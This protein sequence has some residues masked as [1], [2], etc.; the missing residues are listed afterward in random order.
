MIRIAS[1]T[2]RDIHSE[3][4]VL[5]VLSG[6]LRPGRAPLSDS[7]S[8]PTGSASAN[9]DRHGR[10]GHDIQWHPATGRAVP[11]PGAAPPGTL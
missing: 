1:A 2:Y 11:V 7:D 9:R 5:P 3:S 8:E 4:L 6:S 10:P